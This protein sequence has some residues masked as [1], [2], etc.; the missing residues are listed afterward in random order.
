MAR[1]SEAVCRLCRRENQ[2][3]FLKGD[4]CQSAKCAINKRNFAP[5][6][7]GLSRGRKISPYGQ[8]LREK[9]RTKRYYGLLEKQFRRT[10]ERADRMTGVTGTQLLQLLETRLDNLVYRMGFAS[11]RPAARQ[12]VRHGHVRVDGQ[13]VNIPS[14]QVSV[15]QTVTV[16]DKLREHQIVSTGRALAD[17]LPQMSWLEYNADQKTGR[18]LNLPER[19]DIPVEFNEQLIVELYSK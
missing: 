8:Q 4:R 12:L 5:G 13:K 17:K 2:K 9:Q 15:G 19:Q 18:L 10:F 1:Y 14:Y 6:Q 16:K 7:H 11:S 3:L